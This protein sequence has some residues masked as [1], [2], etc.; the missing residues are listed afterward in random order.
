MQ[1][2]LLPTTL[3]VNTPQ[4]LKGTSELRANAA[5]LS[6]EPTTKP[7]AKVVAKTQPPTKP[8]AKVENKASSRELVL[9]TQADLEQPLLDETPRRNSHSTNSSHSDTGNTAYCTKSW[10]GK[11][12]VVFLG[13]TALIINAT[14]EIVSAFESAGNN[15]RIFPCP[16]DPDALAV[17]P[18]TPATQFSVVIALGLYTLQFDL[19]N[20]RHGL[21]QVTTIMCNKALPKEW[22]EV[23]TQKKYSNCKV[24]VIIGGCILVSALSLSSE[25]MNTLNYLKWNEE[26]ENSKGP[27]TSEKV[28]PFLQSLASEP[29]IN[30][31][32]AILGNGAFALCEGTAPIN[33]ATDYL[34]DRLGIE[35]TVTDEK[36]GEEKTQIKP[37]RMLD[38]ALSAPF[39]FSCMVGST[40]FALESSKNLLGI[41]SWEEQLAM[42]LL[43]NSHKGFTAGA[44]EGS[45]FL[46][47]VGRFSNAIRNILQGRRPTRSQLAGFQLVAMTGSFCGELQQLLIDRMFK[48]VDL[49]PKESLPYIAFFWTYLLLT[50]YASAFYSVPIKEFFVSAAHPFENCFS[51]IMHKLASYTNGSAMM[52]QETD[53][54]SDEAKPVAI[55]SRSE[56]LQRWLSEKASSVRQTFCGKR[57]HEEAL[58]ESENPSPV[59]TVVTPKTQTL[60]QGVSQNGLNDKKVESKAV[61]QPKVTVIIQPVNSPR[62]PGLFT[63]PVDPSKVP[64]LSDQSKPPAPKTASTGMKAG[65]VGSA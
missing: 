60:T 24:Y 12:L 43:V 27:Q 21:D 16:G 63:H 40:L 15:I 36:T 42:A 1:R 57:P 62:K 29:V 33:F 35:N 61:E 13:T 49:V 14:T 44:Y 34:G 20:L 26:E 65:K 22:K 8:E 51:S 25:I 47:N 28:A 19:T 17:V 41:E 53:T 56:R 5:T 52:E 32:S 54:P 50:N 9:T 4:T 23:F 55:P 48:N 10:V 37:F 30:T 2:P 31:I 38:K 64:L 11:K 7:E 58:D 46:Q 3:V 39:I 18:N 45:Y 59:S 6:Q